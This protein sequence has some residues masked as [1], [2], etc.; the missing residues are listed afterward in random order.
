MKN[1]F[2]WDCFFNDNDVFFTTTM[3]FLNDNRDNRN[4]KKNG[5]NCGMSRGD[6]QQRQQDYCWPLVNYALFL[7]DNKI[8]VAN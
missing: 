2:L 8:S 4:N 5:R 1:D 6:I 3:S 7:D